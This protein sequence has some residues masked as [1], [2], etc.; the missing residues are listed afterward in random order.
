MFYMIEELDVQLEEFWV[1]VDYLILVGKLGEFGLIVVGLGF[2][3]FFDLCMDEVEVCCGVQGGILC[4]IEGLLY[5]LGVFEQK[6]FVCMDKDL[7]LGDIF[8]M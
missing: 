2:E 7:Q 4:I 1:V 8:F 3:Y 5:V 6:G